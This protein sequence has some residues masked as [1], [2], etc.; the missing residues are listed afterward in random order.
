MICINLKPNNI[1]DRENFL[2]GNYNLKFDFLKRY[3]SNSQYYHNFFIIDQ[4]SQTRKEIRLRVNPNSYAYNEL[5]VR[6]ISDE[7][8]SLI[9]IFL[10]VFG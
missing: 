5:G 1:L 10:N 6:E 4:I 9:G 7:S 8:P 2:E 3:K